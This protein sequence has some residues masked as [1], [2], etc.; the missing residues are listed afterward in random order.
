[1]FRWHR[2]VH[3]LRVNHSKIANV[4]VRVLVHNLSRRILRSKYHSVP[5][6]SLEGNL[7]YA[8][9]KIWPSYVVT[10]RKNKKIFGGIM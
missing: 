7:I 8:L 3:A 6:Y 9:R 10:E 1:M 5:R 2:K 4:E